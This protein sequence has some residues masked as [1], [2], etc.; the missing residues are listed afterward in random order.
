VSANG[1]KQGSSYGNARD[2]SALIITGQDEDTRFFYV[3]AAP[4]ARDI[5]ARWAALARDKV[6]TDVLDDLTGNTTDL[7]ITGD[8]IRRI[9]SLLGGPK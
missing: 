4:E 9:K 5:C 2:G 8:A 6:I 1:G 3:S 7:D